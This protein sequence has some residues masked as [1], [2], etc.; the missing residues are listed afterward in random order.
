MNRS[1]CDYLLLVEGVGAKTHTFSLL[2]LLQYIHEISP[3]E[4]IR[5]SE[6][7]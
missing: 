6:V 3:H 2:S 1:T 4:G 5:I 7:P